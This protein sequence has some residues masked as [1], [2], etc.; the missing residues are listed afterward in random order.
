M[1][2]PSRLLTLAVAVVVIAA[3]AGT[4]GRDGLDGVDGADGAN[5]LD[6]A[7]GSDGMDGPAGPPGNDGAEGTQGD[8][9]LPGA[10][11]ERGAPGPPG[12]RGPAG[13]SGSIDHRAL[14]GAYVTYKLE[15]GGPSMQSSIR[16]AQFTDGATLIT[17]RVTGTVDQILPAQIHTNTRLETGPVVISLNPVD[18]FTGISETS[19]RELD[20]GAPIT[21]DDLVAFDGYVTLHANPLLLDTILASADIGANAVSGEHKTYNL[22]EAAASGISGTAT[23]EKRNN[24]TTLVTIALTGTVSGTDL[25]VHFHNDDVVASG[26]IVISLNNVL[27]ATGL[28]R[29][30]VAQRDDATHILYDELLMLDANVDVHGAGGAI[31]AQGNIGS[32]AP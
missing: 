4:D 3:C 26:S 8:P 10:D 32:N 30:N 5:G 20:S 29:T 12:E 2:H 14:T 15:P 23:L 27:G 6:G 13:A 21:Y 18:G 19:V 17:I 1:I 16:F 11:A 9:G 22:G 28:S 24:G 7:D 31:V 25:A